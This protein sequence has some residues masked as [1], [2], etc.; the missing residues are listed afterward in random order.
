MKAREIGERKRLIFKT[1][2]IETK[3][4]NRKTVGKLTINHLRKKSL[5]LDTLTKTEQNQA[6]LVNFDTHFGTMPQTFVFL[7]YLKLSAEET[8]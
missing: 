6:C 4:E 8:I 2:K 5:E 7:P 3:N 1:K